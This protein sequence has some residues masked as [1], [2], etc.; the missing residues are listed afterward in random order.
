[1][2]IREVTEDGKKYF[3]VY[4]DVKSKVKPGA[5]V[6]KKRKQI[7]NLREAQTIEKQMI[8][9]A[10]MEL[11]RLEDMSM[12]WG[13]L[14][15]LYEITLRSGRATMVKMQENILRETIAFLRAWTSDWYK[16]DCREITPGDVRR[17]INLMEE[18]DYSRGRMRSLKTAVNGVFRFGI[19]E[20]HLNG[21]H[22]SP[23]QSVQLAKY[24]EDKPPQILSMAE[25]YRL[26][27]TAQEE[28]HPWY[29]I[30]FMALNT[31]MRSGELY[32]LEWTDLDWEKKLVTVSKSWNA[33]MKRVKSTKAGYWRKVP[34][35]TELEAMLVDLR[36]KIPMSQKEVLPRV[37]RW[38]NGEAAKFLRDHCLKIGISSVNFHALRACFATH[39]LNAG[40]SSPIV[41]K[42]CGWTEEKVMNRYIRLAGLDVAGATATLNFPSFTNKE[43]KMGKIVN[44]RDAMASRGNP[45]NSDQTDGQ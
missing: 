22:A 19:D 29:P 11:A 39:L 28:E 25:I 17:I 38:G 12:L 15:D 13:E 34:M 33:R 6:Q 23:A 27:K 43:H 24:V 26:L 2:A 36:G 37:S 7:R 18:Q 3:E 8:S 16:R 42:I 44:I 14:L 4:V 10:S 45:T 21:I 40:V 31:G 20:G 35:N 30:W 41:K 1:M 5:R 32:A 9:E